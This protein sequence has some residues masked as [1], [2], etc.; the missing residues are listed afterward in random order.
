MLSSPMKV[1]ERVQFVQSQHLQKRL[2]KQPRLGNAGKT[3]WTCSSYD[4]FIFPWE[5]LE[6]GYSPAWDGTPCGI[7]WSLL[8]H[9]LVSDSWPL[10]GRKDDQT[11]QSGTEFA[12]WGWTS[13]FAVKKKQVFCFDTKLSSKLKKG[14]SNIGREYATR[15]EQPS[16]NILESRVP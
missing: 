9:Q 12:L 15:W 16:F 6:V 13:P 14:H 2:R 7:G 1:G 5:R 4:M 3:W 11:S 10:G 8:S